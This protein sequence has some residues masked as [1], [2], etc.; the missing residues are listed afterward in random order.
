MSK[1]NI[2]I[3]KEL[4]KIIKE[5]SGNKEE[6]SLDTCIQVNLYETQNIS[7]M[8]EEKY[9]NLSIDTFSGNSEQKKTGNRD[10]SS[11]LCT[12]DEPND[13]YKLFRMTEKGWCMKIG[14]A[15]V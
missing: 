5:S 4:E 8:I 11:C 3:S 13:R 12:S 1:K 9:E 14:R 2:S 7:M 6:A 10:V 15:H